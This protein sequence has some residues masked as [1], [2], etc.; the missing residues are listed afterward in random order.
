MPHVYVRFPL[1]LACSL[2]STV[3]KLIATPLNMSH[4]RRGHYDPIRDEYNNDDDDDLDQTNASSAN[5]PSETATRY[6]LSEPDAS[7]DGKPMRRTPATAL[8]ERRQIRIPPWHTAASPYT[9]DGYWASGEREPRT[10]PATTVAEGERAF[11]DPALQRPPDSRIT[12]A[13][14]VPGNSAPAR[15]STEHRI[16]PPPYPPH[17]RQS[18]RDP[19]RAS[20]PS[21]PNPSDSTRATFS[22][23]RIPGSSTSA[24]TSSSPTRPPPPAHNASAGRSRVRAAPRLA[25]EPSTSSGARLGV[26]V[27]GPDGR[28]KDVNPGESVEAYANDDLLDKR[29]DYA[30]S[31]LQA[32]GS[33]LVAAKQNVKR[34]GGRC[35]QCSDRNKPSGCTS[36]V[37]SMIPV[38]G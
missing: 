2:S 28:L 19:S 20:S 8:E 14:S 11:R 12:T 3:Q 26:M 33:A 35:D 31:T 6:H 16:T 10:A 36:S 32:S 38:N 13:S 29:G 34:R 1:N 18:D 27:F 37:R 24:L 15:N 7:L 30:T 21:R 22:R 17:D 25:F 4:R 9:P 5:D 23:T